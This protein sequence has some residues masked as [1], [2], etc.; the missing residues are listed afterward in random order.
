MQS[1]WLHI[2]NIAG[3]AFEAARIQQRRGINSDAINPFLTHV[4]SHPIWE[5]I[6]V[7][8]Y[9]DLN[10]VESLLKSNPEWKSP[11]YYYGG[12]LAEAL[13]L[14]AEK[15]GIVLQDSIS[16]LENA[17]NRWRVL[18][19][20]TYRKLKALRQVMKITKIRFRINKNR[21]L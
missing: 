5:D 2:G 10:D 7:S 3:N 6:E 17:M 14:L 19:R 13:R 8:T 11:T 9:I 18:G 21:C 1:G 4:M 15:R 20:F 16:F 12:D